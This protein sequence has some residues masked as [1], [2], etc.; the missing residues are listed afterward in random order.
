MGMWQ[1]RNLILKLVAIQI[2]VSV[3]VGKAIVAFIE[4]LLCNAPLVLMHKCWLKCQLP[5]GTVL[6][7]I[8]SGTKLRLDLDDPGFA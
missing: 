4:N 6:R 7:L 1:K 3:D 2:P 5:Y 8:C